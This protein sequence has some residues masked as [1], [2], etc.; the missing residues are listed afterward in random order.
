VWRSINYDNTLSLILILY[1]TGLVGTQL[2]APTAVRYSVVLISFYILVVFQLGAKR[3]FQISKQH[4]KYYLSFLLLI[5]L[6]SFYGGSEVFWSNLLITLSSVVTIIVYEFFARVRIKENHV[7][8]FIWI[9]M[10][11]SVLYA[12]LSS[13]FDKLYFLNQNSVPILMLLMV[14]LCDLY[15]A[16]KKLTILFVWCFALFFTIL[17]GSRAGLF[18]LLSYLVLRNVKSRR[19][20]TFFFV[21]ALVTLVVLYVFGYSVYLPFVF[22]GRPIYYLAKR[23]SLWS[24]A[25]ELVV[26]HPLG[27]GY[28]GY[29]GVFQDALGVTLSVHNTYLNIL[30]QFGWLYFI[31]YLCFV[32][33]LLKES[34]LHITSALIFSAYLRAF[35]E[36]STPFGLSLSSALL[37]LPLYLEM[38]FLRSE[39]NKSE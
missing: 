31:F 39:S 7:Y 11:F 37:L 20:Q 13:N 14:Y 10:G 21:A 15:L 4:I 18:A 6:S 1:L 36:S 32:T 33:R 30:L 34:K 38:G 25:S 22:L 26:A 24:L 3:D 12:L 2:A 23:E 8:A 16:E 5:N 19:L 28:A 35:F 29:E 17:S 9:V 27:M